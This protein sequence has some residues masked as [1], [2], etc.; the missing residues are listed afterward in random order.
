MTV[1]KEECE[2]A[3]LECRRN[4]SVARRAYDELMATNKELVLAKVAATA[5][6]NQQI[7][8]LLSESMT[9][10]SNECSSQINTIKI[11]L[12]VIVV[13]ALLGIIVPYAT[14]VSDISGLKSSVNSI[15]KSVGDLN[16]SI[17]KSIGNLSDKVDANKH[18][19]M[20]HQ[21][22]MHGGSSYGADTDTHSDSSQSNK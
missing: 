15:E 8:A 20:L 16:T 13:S 17:N 21:M 11:W 3:R 7:Y 14:I 5:L 19:F 18:N 9:N 4:Q 12:F 22:Y 2:K 10:S 6:H 1:S